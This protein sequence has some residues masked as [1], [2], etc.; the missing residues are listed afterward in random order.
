M[1]QFR[2][3]QSVAIKGIVTG[4]DVHPTG[5]EYLSVERVS[6]NGRMFSVSSEDVVD[7]ETLLSTK[8]DLVVIPL[9]IA[10][11]LE[12]CKSYSMSLA[13]A[14]TRVFTSCEDNV[15]PDVHTWLYQKDNQEIFA[16]AWIEGYEVEKEP[17]YWVRNRRGR[18][19]LGKKD[20]GTIYG[21]SYVTITSQL[22][23][24]KSYTFTEKE[25]KDYD[26]RYWA[27]AVPVEEE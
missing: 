19:M 11:Y 9:L 5:V 1:R 21:A 15:S 23:Y 8:K 25:I 17:L 2:M 24:P 16:R 13:S 26:E 18:A 12:H 4:I 10:G 7:L 27:F 20:D 14:L 22:A 6:G 3:G